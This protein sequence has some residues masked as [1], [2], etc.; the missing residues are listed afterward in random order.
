M[1]VEAVGHQVINSRIFGEDEAMHSRDPNELL[2]SRLTLVFSEASSTEAIKAEVQKIL[3]ASGIECTAIASNNTINTFEVTRLPSTLAQNKKVSPKFSIVI[4]VYNEEHNIP[5]LYQR[6]TDVM[7]I[8][9]ESYEIIFVNDGSKD[10]SLGILKSLRKSDQSHIRIINFSRNFGHQRAISAGIDHARGQAVLIMDADLQDPPEVIPKFVEKWREG[11]EVVYAVREKRKEHILKRAA[12]RTFY[13]ILRTVAKIDIPLDTGDFCLMDRRVV[14]AIKA[15]PERNRFVRGLRTWVGFKQT[16]LSYEREARYAGETKYTFRKLVSLALDGLL[17]FSYLPLRLATMVGFGISGL[18]LL[19]AL[20][21][22]AKAI[23]RG[24]NPPGF[25]TQVV[26]ITFLGGVQLITIGIIGE[27]IGQLL[28]EVKHRPT[29]V[30]RE[31]IENRRK[32]G[33]NG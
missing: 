15:L 17:A 13:L 21:Y 22:F 5:E 1:F 11:Y 4:P 28:E 7:D 10:K 25:A 27:Y 19:A 26:L 14:D 32:R 2:S 16:G 20:Y 31:V 29:Y 30:V 33:H 12:Y 9:S 3:E 6:L 23:T 18:S 24:L 8:L